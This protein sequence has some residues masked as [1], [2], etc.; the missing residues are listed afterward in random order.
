MKKLIALILALFKRKP[1]PDPVPGPSPI[2]PVI[3]HPSEAGYKLKTY[4]D[5]VKNRFHWGEWTHT[6]PGNQIK[7]GVCIN[8]ENCVIQ[9]P[10]GLH[11]LA[12][13]GDT[14]DTNNVGMIATHQFLEILYGYIEVTAKVPPRGFLYWFSI[15]MYN[16]RG[17]QPEIDIIECMGPDAKSVCITHH[18]VGPDGKDVSEGYN[19]PTVDLS[20]DFHRYGIEWT[21]TR[22]TWYLDGV[23]KYSTQNQIPQVP[24]FLICNMQS[25]EYTHVYTPGEV[26]AKAVIQ[27]IEIWNK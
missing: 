14:D 16:K 13:M 4:F 25:R 3:F 8:D 21:P 18:W 5:F 15:W 19:L 22:L 9:K 11:L 7:K 27:K 10:D 6:Y 12:E 23:A 2:I 17:W 1:A 26:P 24:L 20:L